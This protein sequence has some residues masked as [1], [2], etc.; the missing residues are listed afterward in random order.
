MFVSV[1]RQNNEALIILAI[2]GYKRKRIG[3]VKIWKTRHKISINIRIFSQCRLT[4]CTDETSL[5]GL[6]AADAVECHGKFPHEKFPKRCSFSSKYFDHLSLL[7]RGRKTLY[8]DS[9]L[10][11]ISINSVRYSLLF[12]AFL[13]LLSYSAFTP[14]EYRK[15]YLYLYLM[16]A[17]AAMADYGF[18]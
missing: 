12:V 16:R 8:P 17:L 9:V 4:A 11:C 18:P 7:L 6:S 1:N 14:Q 5:I 2:Y 10:S 15:K 3:S 13:V